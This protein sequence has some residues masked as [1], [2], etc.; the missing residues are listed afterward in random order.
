MP[1]LQ[2]RLFYVLHSSSTALKNAFFSSRHHHLFTLSRFSTATVPNPSSAPPF[3]LQYLINSCGLSSGD[4]AEAAKHIAHLKSPSNPDSVLR[5]LKQSGFTDAN[6]RKLVSLHPRVLCSKVEKTLS[7]KFVA[8]LDMG[9]PEAEMVQLVSSVPRTIQI[10]DPRPKIEFWRSLFGTQ[11]NLLKALKR[12]PYLISCNVGKRILP[13]VS[14]LRD[15]GIPDCRIGKMVLNSPRFITMNLDSLK[16]VIE[17]AE[18]LGVPRSS[19]M[20]W[21]ALSAVLCSSRTAVDAKFRL[22]KSLG[23]SESEIASAVSKTPKLLHFSEK[24]IRAK[25]DFLTKEAG[26]ELSY[27]AFHPVLLMCSLERRLIPRNHVLRILKSKELPE[28]GR[29]FFP[30][31]ALT[32]ENFLKKFVLPNEKKIPGLSEAYMAACTGKVPIACKF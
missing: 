7:P 27:V 11:E 16:V 2:R 31:I 29:D 23:W 18:E 4:A 6:I 22:L 30:A 26:L 3:L 24:R 19:G 1:P 5:F 20:F 28:G 9:F 25:M 15:C 13:N 32:E 8:L 12:N 10:H 17:R 14:L 21:Q